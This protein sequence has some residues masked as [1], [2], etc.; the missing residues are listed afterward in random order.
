MTDNFMFGVTPFYFVR[1]GET[2][3]SRRG[4]LQGQTETELSARGRRDAE[5]VGQTLIPLGIRSI[6]T[7]PLK[8]TRKTAAIISVMID[9]PV[10]T[11]PGLMERGWGRFE[12]RPKNERPKVK[13][14]KTAETMADFSARVLDAFGSIAGPSPVLVISHSG[15][16]RVL[17]AQI[18][19]P[20]DQ[21]A[22][23]GNEQLLQI[24]PP[25]ASR[26][27]W[28]IAEVGPQG[29]PGRL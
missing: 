29:R 14:P 23:V 24:C 17:A 10:F 4:I 8:R 20:L 3:E 18:A 13:N 7:S 6:Y 1:H 21:S 27:T 28:R 11:L 2:R 5:N 22:S 19:I 16:F 25:T 15:V 26:P 9:A 12:G